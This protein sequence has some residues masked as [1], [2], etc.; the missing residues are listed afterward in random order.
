MIQPTAEPFIYVDSDS[1]LAPL[2]ARLQKAPRAAL[3]TE[4]DSLHSY[5][6][7]VCLIQIEV[8]GRI[9]LVDPLSDVDLTEFLEVLADKPLIFHG[10]EYDLRMM[11]ASF[12]FRPRV[13]VFDT[14]LAAQLLGYEQFGLAALVER[15]F[16]VVLPKT[17]Q[18]SDWSKRPLTDAQLEYA[19]D[20][21]R[22]L[23]ALADRLAAKLKEIGRKD[24]HVESCE[25]MVEATGQENGRDPEEAWRIKGVSK[26]THHEMVFAREIWRWRESE[27]R[28]SDRPPFKVL[29]NQALIDLAAWA[30]KHT[31]T[32]LERGPKLPR[33]CRGKRL[34]AL[35]RAIRR[36]HETPKS[37]W[38]AL[39]KSRG[40]KPSGPEPTKLI[41][42][43]RTECARIAGELELPPSVLAPRA[44]MVAVAR[45]RPRSI[46]STMKAGPLMKWQAELL[47]PSIERLLD[48]YGPTQTGIEP[49]A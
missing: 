24:W 48:E 34:A 1:T 7:K 2:T 45:R 20:D 9:Y 44:A 11:R 46:E 17:G 39:H 18:R 14:M 16:E 5:F 23:G 15:Y 36:A 28:R 41:D 12:G 22:Y 27:A 29:G 35:K 10:A 19:G 26:L 4:A 33:N 6:E 38:P 25:R 13:A 43:L 42:A 31:R 30:A 40:K 21:V 3:D 49:R 32:P 47:A 8:K 37:Q